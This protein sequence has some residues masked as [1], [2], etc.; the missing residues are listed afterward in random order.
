LLEVG[1]LAGPALFRAGFAFYQSVV[2]VLVSQNCRNYHRWRC[3]R[4][5]DRRSNRCRS[6]PTVDMGKVRNHRS[7]PSRVSRNSRQRH[8]P[9]KPGPRQVRNASQIRLDQHRSHHQRSRPGRFRLSLVRNQ[10]SAQQ[11][12]VRSLRGCPLLRRPMY[13]SEA[14]HRAVSSG[15]ATHSTRSAN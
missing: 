8:K 12:K 10:T 13:P 4:F 11:T 5:W 2:L 7:L 1:P 3:S 9:A 6:S 14:S 15:S